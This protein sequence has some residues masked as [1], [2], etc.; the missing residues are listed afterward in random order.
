MPA[1]ALAVCPDFHVPDANTTPSTSPMANGGKIVIDATACDNGFGLG[2]VITNPAHGYVSIDPFADTVTYTHSGDNA[3]S[4]QFVFSDDH[5]AHINVFVSIA[6]A[7][8]PI[9]VSPASAPAVQVGTPVNVALG[10]T[11][12]TDPYTFTLTSGTLPDGLSF[13]GTAITGIPTKQG[14]F[15]STFT[16]TDGATPALTTTKT[17]SFTVPNPTITLTTLP[18][19]A[20]NIPYSE[21]VSASGSLGPYTFTLD[22][23]SLPTGLTLNANG[24]VSGTTTAAVG[25]QF[26]FSIK[27]TDST[28]SHYFGAQSFTLTVQ[29]APPISVT[30]TTITTPQVGASYTQTL[31]ASGGT[32]PYAFAVIS[33]SLPAGLTLTGNTI[34]GTPTSTAPANFTIRA[35]DALSNTGSRAYSVTPNQPIIN[36]APATLPNGTKD[37]A[38]SQGTTASGGTA[39][40]TYSIDSGTVP[41]GLSLNPASG[42]L[43]GTPT[44]A[45]TF[46]FNVAVTD[47]TTGTGPFSASRSY[48]VVIDPGAPVITTSS[49]G[50]A[51][52]GVAYNGAVA[53]TGGTAPLTFSATALPPGLSIAA[54]G[55]ITGTPTAGGTF[56]PSFTVTDSASLTGNTTLQLRVN[57][58][59]L[60]ITPVTLPNGTRYAA[61]DQTLIA[62]GAT[63]PYSFQLSGGTLPTGITLD[64]SGRLHGSTTQH[65]SFPIT[66]TVTDSSTGSGPYSMTR[67]YTLD[68]DDVVIAITPATLVPA[69]A[70]N[71]YPP[72]TFA[73]SGGVQPY[74]YILSGAL[75]PGMSFTGSGTLSGTPTA[76]GTY[77]FTVTSTD[78]GSSQGSVS[79]TFVVNHSTMT[80]DTSPVPAGAAGQAYSHTFPVSGGVAPYHFAISSGALPS[81]VTLNLTTGVLSGTPT[82]SGTFPFSITVTDS[83]STSPNQS[84]GN[85]TLAVAGPNIVVTPATLPSLVVGSPVSEQLNASG[86][87]GASTYS[88]S[89]GATP[90]GITVSSSGLISGTPTTAGPYAFTVTAKDSLNFTGTVAYS[91][92]V[93]F[94]PPVAVADTATT[95]AN[96]AVTIP[97]TTN[98]TGSITSVTVVQAPGHGT[99]SVSGLNAI[100]T[101]ATNFF[102]TDTFNYTATGPGGTS[103]AASVTV[104]VTPAAV[105]VAQPKT[106]TLLAGKSATIAATDGATGGP[107]T[108]VTLSSAPSSGSAVVSG[109]NI[110]YTAATDASG[111]VT[112][113]YTLS[114][115]FG[116]SQPAAV[117]VTVNP[118]PVAPPLNASAQAG[119][120]VQVDLTASAHGGPFTAA[121]V[122]S[123]SPANAGTATVQAS[124][125]GYTLNFAAASTFSGLAQVTYT[126][127]NA[128]ATS[129]PGTVSISVISRP[130]PTKDA[131]VMGI[132]EAQADGTRRMAQGQISNFQRR[133]ESLHDGAAMGVFN[134]GISFSSAGARDTRDPMLALKNDKED[135]NRRYLVQPDDTS[136]ARAKSGTA[137][138]G[139]LPGDLSI[140]TGGAVNFGRSTPGTS[141]NG[142]DFTTSGL[143]V[144]ADKRLSNEFTVGGG[145]G[146]GHDN[147]DVGRN[148]SRSKIDSYN[149]ALYSSYHPNGSMYADALI[150]Y[151]WL[152]LDARR[153]V[154]ETGGRVQGS[155]DGKQWF[156]S[157]ALGYEHRADDML[158]SPYGRLDIAHATLDP[159]TEHG[160]NL[161]ALSY[162][163]Q[164]V[165]TTTGSL[166]VR[167]EW[168]AKRDYGIWLPRL[169]AE[170][171][172]DFQGSS[173]ATMRYADLLSGPVYRASLLDQSHNHM[174]L[175]AGIQLQMLRG[176]LIRFEYQNLLDNTTRDNQSVTFGLEKT[177]Q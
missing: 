11:G 77:N 16:V 65:G 22:S 114:N 99:V 106:V 119:T 108:A 47:S 88:V 167:L 121:S 10:A 96:V 134:N 40:Y 76:T 41:T 9:V 153:Y 55:Q 150:G 139:S 59:A 149:V 94:A 70:G 116:V 49:L 32:G 2:L 17:Y 86:G 109:Q 158:V 147:T 60:N 84:T 26:T 155:R 38:Y 118:L 29:A 173:D 100:Y 177:F 79:Y 97:V 152:Q 20:I 142:T 170:Y 145:V 8:S 75:P 141:A 117:T 92:T 156:G 80:F 103:T 78:A 143:S 104:T 85:F 124:A 130:D 72:V 25:Q 165:K 128:Y 135:N 50:D 140:W 91:G 39:P 133:L 21:Q 31:G 18:N 19:P 82:M 58:P 66:V 168:A 52:V 102:G 64:S 28:T 166:G 44:Q 35:T 67:A 23:G 3:T 101:P 54:N 161:Y 126:L 127:S 68:I 125:T 57:A 138:D 115:P 36:I 144:G 73:S 157:F 87:I 6:P 93:A 42:L 24:T 90:A 160:D 83:D 120:S 46:S 1:T 105:P 95:Q 123:V 129:A 132:L 172:H 53:A 12:G 111:P 13:T 37:V 45:G 151:Q 154:T 122:V 30:P 5:G 113:S 146:Y 137:A 33:G 171:Q 176:W 56:N 63:A 7:A 107:F 81:G 48:T 131:E 71:A 174:L 74:T 112:F 136:L 163:G 14:T 162:D 43:S 159:Y 51:Q 164:T 15:T 27:A 110:V 98:D 34:S 62:S 169:R 148:G 175:G 4:D 61:Y 89:S 69:T